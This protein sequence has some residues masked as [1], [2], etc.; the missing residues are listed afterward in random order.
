[1]RRVSLLGG[2]CAEMLMEVIVSDALIMFGLK[3]CVKQGH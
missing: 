2:E 1:M 3:I